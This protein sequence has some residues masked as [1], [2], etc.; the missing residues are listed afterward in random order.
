[1]PK[2]LV[3][4]AILLHISRLKA[5]VWYMWV[6]CGNTQVRRSHPT[7]PPSV[8]PSHIPFSDPI[9]Q[10]DNKGSS[11]KFITIVFLCCGGSSQ[12]PAPKAMSAWGQGQNFGRFEGSLKSLH[13]LHILSKAVFFVLPESAAKNGAHSTW[14]RLLLTSSL[15][16]T[17]LAPRLSLGGNRSAPWMTYKWKRNF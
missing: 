17:S 1:M 7:S 11:N 2:G 16:H 10:P 4:T 9:A 15:A 13:S 8:F 5:V 14:F 12:A 6:G 3:F